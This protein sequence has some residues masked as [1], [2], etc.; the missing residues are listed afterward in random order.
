MRIFLSS[1]LIL[2]HFLC[3]SFPSAGGTLDCGN[4]ERDSWAP[5]LDSSYII[6]S[7]KSAFQTLVARESSSSDFWE[8]A[9]KSDKTLQNYVPRLLKNAAA[10]FNS[11]KFTDIT[12]AMNHIVSNTT[13]F[14]DHINGTL[15]ARHITFDTLNEE[16]EGIFMTI[17][18][19]LEKI[20]APNK[21]PGH[22]EREAMVDKVLVDTLQELKKLAA[23]YRIEEEAVTAYLLALK[24]QVKALIVAV[25][26]INEQYP[27]LLPTLAF[28][29]AALL[30]PES[31]I[32]R[33]FLSL[34]GF[35]PIGPMKGSAAALLQR[36]FWG[37]AV[38]S[39]SWFSW[40]QAAGMG[41]M[42]KWAGLV[43]VPLMIGGLSV[44]LLPCCFRR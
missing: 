17:A 20:P 40:L 42:P 35:G 22:A 19:D 13:A 11:T 33:P 27:E 5:F 34:F 37:R 14:R 4:K 10:Y 3:L 21:A 41:T 28:S 18:N 26:D 16:L 6:E 31:W 12:S 30:I 9:K 25:G 39:D 36:I 38:A 8:T 24:P 43:K 32:L 23:H 29:V 1:L 44:M 2:T 7:I 15:D